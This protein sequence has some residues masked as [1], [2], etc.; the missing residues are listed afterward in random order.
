MKRDAGPEQTL[1]AGV[2]LLDDLTRSYG[3]VYAATATGMGSG[4]AFAAGQFR[5]ENRM[6][7]LHYRYSLGLVTYHVGETALSHEDYMW[8]VL[9]ERW[10]SRYPAF[11]KE[12]LDDFRDL[13]ADLETNCTEFLNRI[14]Q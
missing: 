3:F 10:R 1:A 6:M 13:R 2:E 11:P 7:E 5:R 14:G 8:S 4:G 12:P 9:A